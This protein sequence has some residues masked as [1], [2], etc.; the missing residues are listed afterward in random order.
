MAQRSYHVLRQLARRYE[1]DALLFHSRAAPTQL[2]LSARIAHLEGLARVEVFRIPGEWRGRRRWWDRVRSVVTK[3]PELQWRYDSVE[4]RRKVIETVFERDPGLVHVED[5]ALHG[6][7]PLLAGRRV[8]LSHTSVA[9]ERLGGRA[10]LSAGRERRRLERQARWMARAESE[11]L[12]RVTANVA[13]SERDRAVLLERAPAARVEVVPAAVDTTHFRAAE[14]TGHGLVYV[15]GA[16]RA[17]RDALEYFAREILPR[18]RRSLGMQTLEPISWVGGAG[19]E[20]RRRYREVGIDLTGY[21]EDVRPIVRPAA[22]Y[23]VPRRASGGQTRVLQAWAM[24]KAV[25]STPM[26]CEGLDA[27]NGENVLIRETPDEFARAVVE[28]LEDPGLRRRLGQA[29]RR[30]VEAGYGWDRRGRELVALYEELESGAP[31]RGLW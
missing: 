5:M 21:V 10:G 30:T 23:V 11:W 6:C 2:P 24:G 3:R 28:V 27:V 14:G 7:L 20:E 9:S 19:E 18:V 26:A 31:V 15:G 8:V 29:G 16:D 17:N 22:C 12:P 4:Y 25:V 1:V 13:M